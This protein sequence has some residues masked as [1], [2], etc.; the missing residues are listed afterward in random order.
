[1]SLY[2]FAASEM[3]LWTYFYISWGCLRSHFDFSVGH[4]LGFYIH[5][6]VILMKSFPLSSYNLS[7]PLGDPLSSQWTNQAVVVFVY[8]LFLLFSLP[9]RLLPDWIFDGPPSVACCSVTGCYGGTCHTHILSSN[10]H[11]PSS[12]THF[13][14]E[15]ACGV[16]SNWMYKLQNINAIIISTAKKILRYLEWHGFKGV[17]S[18][19]IYFFLIFQN[20]KYTHTVM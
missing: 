15:R 10:S 16:W 5:S 1:M 8:F 6:D 20:K 17:I 12:I 11:L 2:I 9:H 14:S 13:Y 7:L 19:E 4:L 18:W 3:L